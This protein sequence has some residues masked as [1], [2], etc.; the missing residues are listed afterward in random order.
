MIKLSY[1]TLNYLHN[2][3]EFL[4]AQMKIPVPLYDFL[5]Q[6]KEGHR[7][8]Q[9]HLSGEKE[10]PYLKDLKVR[11]PITEREDFDERCKFSFLMETQI[12]KYEIFGF[13]DGLD[14]ENKRLLEIK[15]SNTGWTMSKF[16]DAM[17]RKLYALAYPDYGEQIIVTGS[18]HP[19]KWESNPPK[20]YSLKVSDKDLMDARGW[21]IKGI[22][23]LESGNFKGGLD[24]NGKCT[25]CFWNMD[26]YKGLATCHFM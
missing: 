25:G 22:E 4:N 5:Q 15:L 7:L 13:V 14:R 20:L 16:R 12:G 8:I 6:G 24:E 2:G 9:A 19:E 26:R 1:T 17:Q 18:K 10:H 21:I 3:H 23:I 11:F